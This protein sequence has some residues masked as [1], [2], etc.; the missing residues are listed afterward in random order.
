M[1]VTV[2]GSAASYA[3]AGQACS[4]H[5]IESGETRLLFDCGHGVVANL[6][7][8]IDP[9]DLDGVFITHAHIDHFADIYALQALLRYA[10]HGPAD[11]LPLYVPDGLLETAGCVLSENGRLELARA[12]EVHVVEDG[13][14]VPLGDLT[15][16]VAAVDHIDPTYA[17]VA[18]DG[19]GRVCYTSDTGMTQ[20]VV[21]AAMGCD[22]LLAE[23]TLP[24][25]YADVAPHLTA[26]QAGEVA[27][28][29]GVDRLVLVHIW[30]TTDR[31]A[32]LAEAAEA[33]GGE[34]AVAVEMQAFRVPGQRRTS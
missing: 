3:G 9:L 32:A 20:A 27:R 28:E 25:R 10:P 24:E 34:V 6:S 14:T 31:G 7:A 26:R 12:F 29:A 8:A 18:Q 1:R 15:V 2:L 4:G 23:A 22:L 11:P 19:D 13:S 21:K 30:P 33:F 5:L 16:G 17:L